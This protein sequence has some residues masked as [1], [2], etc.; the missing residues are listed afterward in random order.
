[1]ALE[2][3]A[4]KAFGDMG[5]TARLQL[6]RDRFIAGHSSCEL[7]RP[8]ASVPPDTPIRDVVDRCRV[9]ESHADPAVH[10]VSKPSP[11]Q[12][13][14]AYVAGD[15]DSINE[16]TRVT[17]VTRPRSGPDQLE[18][19]LRRLLLTVDPPAP[20]PEVPPALASAAYVQDYNFDVP[21]GMDLMVHRHSRFPESSDVRQDCQMD[22]A[23]VYQTASY[24][25]KDEWNTSDND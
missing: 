20:I 5:Q 17:A 8:L 24:A 23:P 13:Y 16:T 18:D 19:L 2:T 3:L 11:D 12:T 15:S 1:M 22:V 6:I 9:W 14:P 21:E 25:T 10:R 4:V 7:Q